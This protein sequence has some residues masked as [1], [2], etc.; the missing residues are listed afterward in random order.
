MNERTELEKL[1]SFLETNAHFLQ[2]HPSCSYIIPLT[3]EQLEKNKNK[4]TELP[5]ESV[6][7]FKDHLADVWNDVTSAISTIVPVSLQLEIIRKIGEL[8]HRFAKLIRE[9]SLLGSNKSLGESVDKLEVEW[10]KSCKDLV[11]RVQNAIWEYKRPIGKLY[12][13]EVRRWNA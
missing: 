13:H 7:N 8:I 4:V 3:I 6:D 11:T 5:E 12:K 9:H 2:E 10:E 1:V